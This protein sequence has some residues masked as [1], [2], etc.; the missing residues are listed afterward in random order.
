VANL[1]SLV[2]PIDGLEFDLPWMQRFSDDMATWTVGVRNDFNTDA[3]MAC[4]NGHSWAVNFRVLFERT[5]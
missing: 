1:L 3:S 5:A 4:A 2:C